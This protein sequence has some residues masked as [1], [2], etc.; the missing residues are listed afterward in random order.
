MTR[1]ILVDQVILIHQD[2]I[3]AGP[4]IRRGA[5]EGAVVAPFQ[6]VF[7]QE[8]YP[9]LVLKTAKLIEGISRAQAF[10]DGNKRLAWLS[11][12]ILLE[13]NGLFLQDVDP[14][15]TADFVL[16]IQ[17]DAAGLRTAALWL[18]A[19]VITLR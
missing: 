10:Q 16:G 12:M 6:A 15:E 7:G 17:G 11:G 9:S 4:L 5:L 2:A 1:V 3:G 19:R 14:Q 18:N 8:L 13:T